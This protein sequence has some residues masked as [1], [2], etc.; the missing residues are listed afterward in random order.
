MSCTDG[1][2]SEHATAAAVFT[3]D[4]IRDLDTR[5]AL[6][7]LVVAFYREI[8]FDDMLGPVF[9]EVAETDW[10]VHIPSPHRLLVQDLA[11]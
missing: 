3:S 9:E 4:Q 2:T 1:T 11:R 6:H 5:S 10:V 8:V 7:D